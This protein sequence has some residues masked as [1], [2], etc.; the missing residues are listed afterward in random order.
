MNIQG[1]TKVLEAFVFAIFSW[2]LGAQK[3]Y[4]CQIKA[5]ILKFMWIVEKSEFGQKLLPGIKMKK[6]GC[7]LPSCVK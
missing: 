5:E 6:S 2:S 7:F 1:V 4:S 3:K